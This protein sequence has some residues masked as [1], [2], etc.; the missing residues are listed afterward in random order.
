VLLA[1]A[2]LACATPS[3]VALERAHEL[4]FLERT[5]AGDPFTHVVLTAERPGAAGPLFVYLEGDADPQRVAARLPFD[6]TPRHTLALEL[7]GADPGPALYL[8]RPAQLGARAPARSWTRARYGEEVVLS[9][10]AA[11]GRSGATRDH[12]GLVLVGVSGG[13]TLATLLAERIPEARALVTVGA[14]LDVAAWARHRG[15]PP[16]V[17]S[18]D[19]ARR[20]PLRASLIQLHLQGERDQIV[21]PATTAAFLAR[22]PSPRVR[23]VPE[24]DHRCCWVSVWPEVA[25]SLRAE[26]AADAP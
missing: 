25:R 9:L 4:G 18:L 6:G 23:L 26:L 13:G 8:G 10:A 2:A 5:V 11:L 14:N 22:Q 7:M 1:C 17:E 20:P 3:E 12:R 21:P 16:L 19:P 15:E 24:F